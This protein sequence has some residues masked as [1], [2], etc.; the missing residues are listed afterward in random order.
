M[1]HV[2]KFIAIEEACPCKI[3]HQKKKI[4]Y[5]KLDGMICQAYNYIFL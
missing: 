5:L 4:G 2:V 3:L 1:N